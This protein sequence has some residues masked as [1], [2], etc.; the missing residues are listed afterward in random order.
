VA[1][2]VQCV[3]GDVPPRGVV[4][5]VLVLAFFIL[6]PGVLSCWPSAFRVDERGV[7]QRWYWRWDLWPWEAFAG[8]LVR[9]TSA[10]CG[11]E[12]PDKPWYSRRM[13]FSILNDADC[14]WVMERVLQVWKPP[15]VEVPE[16]IKLRSHGLPNMYLRVSPRGVV[17]AEEK[18]EPAR[19]YRWSEVLRARMKL[20]RYLEFSPRGIVF[21]RVTDG[22]PRHY[23]W[24]DVV[25]VRVRRFAHWRQDCSGLELEFPAGEPTAF[26]GKCPGRSR[27]NWTG[28]DARVVLA[29]LRRYV[30]EERV[31]FTA[32]TGPP[33]TPDEAGRRRKELEQ[34][35]RKNRTGVRVGWA[36]WG[37][38]YLLFLL[39]AGNP[40]Q[41]DWARWIALGILGAMWGAFGVVIWKMS[42]ESRQKYERGLA[43]LTTPAA[44]PTAGAFGRD[45]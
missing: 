33:R 39:M 32:S 35:F 6:P 14:Q 12:Y 13:D 10:I 16:E 41:L 42:S 9:H 37:L 5:I 17:F 3:Y 19:L 26:L 18:G 36:T 38:L 25:Q 45:G 44:G 34:T 20:D 22:E 24:S 40:L 15:T 4:F 23:R 7:W 8:G 29:Y 31:Q 1:I 30:G 28:A 2:G 11:W 21:S 27:C 43:E